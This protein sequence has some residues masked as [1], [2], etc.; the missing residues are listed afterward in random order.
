MAPTHD[1][2][3]ARHTGVWRALSITVHHL[4]DL[5]IGLRNTRQINAVACQLLVKKCGR[6]NCRRLRKEDISPHVMTVPPECE[7]VK[8][9][10]TETHLTKGGTP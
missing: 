9:G 7:N 4:T 10:G 2:R 1:G 5:D 3:F 6:P 8:M